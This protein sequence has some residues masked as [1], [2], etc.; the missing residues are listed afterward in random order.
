MQDE[1]KINPLT[2]AELAEE[3]QRIIDQTN[4]FPEHAKRIPLDNH[5]LVSILSFIRLALEVS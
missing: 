3:I 5:D 1:E 2:K 4:E